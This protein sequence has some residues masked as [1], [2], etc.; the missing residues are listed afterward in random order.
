MAKSSLDDSTADA[1]VAVVIV[2]V[3][4]LSVVEWLSGLPA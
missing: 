3:A 2:S 1:V 4:V